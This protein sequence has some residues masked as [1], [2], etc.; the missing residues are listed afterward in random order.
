MDALVGLAST[1]VELGDLQ[2]AE[3]V[4]LEGQQA[5]DR[6]RTAHHQ[7]R[8]RIVIAQRELSHGRPESAIPILEECL[9]RADRLG[10][11]PEQVLALLLLADAHL[12]ASATQR[13]MSELERATDLIRRL[14]YNQIYATEMRQMRDLLDLAVSSSVDEQRFAPLLE[15]A[16][17]AAQLAGGTVA[18]P[19]VP[20]GVVSVRF[21]ALGLPQVHV[22]GHEVSDL[23]WRSERA[24]E[25]LLLFLEE[26]RPLGKQGIVNELWP[27]IQPAKLNGAFHSTLYRLRKA[28]G[29]GVVVH[30][31][32]GYVLGDGFNIELDAHDFRRK[33]ELA[34]GEPANSRSR[35]RL[36]EEAIDLYE[37]PFADSFDSEW[38][39][40]LR[41]DLED[42][43]AAALLELAGIEAASDDH[44]RALRFADQAKRID[45]LSEQATRL[46][47]ES[48]EAQGHPDMAI[49][50][51]ERYARVTRR[52]LG[53]EPSR[54]LQVIR[55]RLGRRGK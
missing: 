34:R 22:E 24:K 41:S 27:D 20:R 48:Y 6:S 1:L 26:G 35:A 16:E 14:G 32:S 36:L 50:T 31:D 47:M 53:T 23:E 2:R 10:T 25:M 8:F 3:A 37:G 39:L 46:L 38:I 42:R 15:V 43:L 55:D 29:Q 28:V 30:S 19:G 40:S 12:R 5:A 7:L 11:R 13:A 9:E 21:C 49:R 17:R 18:D 45:P 51:Y 4:L 52:E 54:E 33:L 44:H